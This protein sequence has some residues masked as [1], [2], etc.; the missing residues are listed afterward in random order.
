MK[1]LA[2][3]IR[4]FTNKWPQKQNWNYSCFYVSF[5]YIVYNIQRLK[6]CLWNNCGWINGNLQIEPTVRYSLFL[7]RK[8]KIPVYLNKQEGGVIN[9]IHAARPL[10]WRRIWE[11]I[12]DCTVARNHTSVKHVVRLF[13]GSLSWKDINFCTVSSKNSTSVTNAPRSLC[14]R[15]TWQPTKFCIVKEVSRMFVT[16]VGRLL[17][18][19]GTWENIKAG[20]GTWIHISLLTQEKNAT[21][22]KNVG[23][24]L[25][26]KG[27]WNYISIFTVGNLTSVTNVTKALFKG[28]S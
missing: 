26:V 27:P 6:V 4:D 23:K 20:K 16:S 3:H 10:L 9:A 8:L 12:N 14:M 18:P 21:S 24:L 13:L 1:N 17:H 7:H 25:P 28:P 11:G 19:R 22:V 15:G 2:F 5:C